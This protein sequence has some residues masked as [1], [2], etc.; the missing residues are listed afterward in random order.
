V[1]ACCIPLPNRIR[2]V[3]ATERPWSE[4]PGPTRAS[5]TAH[6]HPSKFSPRWQP[7]RITAA[8]APSAFADAACAEE[9]CD[10]FRSHSL[11][12]GLRGVSEDT[13]LSPG[14][15]LP[16]VSDDGRTWTAIGW[17]TC[18][19]R[20]SLPP[21]HLTDP[22]CC[23]PPTRLSSMALERASCPAFAV[24][25]PFFHAY[26]AWMAVIRD[27]RRVLVEVRRSLPWP[28]GLPHRVRGRER[29]VGVTRRARRRMGFPQDLR[30]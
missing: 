19:L 21:S 17:R 25:V 12:P 2:C 29:K 23:D 5:P 16:V 27:P 9:P 4:D 26:L 18:R 13:P 6:S 15:S 3:S 20:Q 14:C 7:Y 8:V 1:W 11:R 22:A 10:S 28:S 30:R 24:A